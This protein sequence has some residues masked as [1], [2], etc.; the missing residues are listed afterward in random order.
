MRY[1]MLRVSACPVPVIARQELA[2]AWV[3]SWWRCGA[4][5]RIGHKNLPSAV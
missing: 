3:V 2:A 5:G 1:M 4:C